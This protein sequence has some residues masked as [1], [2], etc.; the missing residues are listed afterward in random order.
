MTHGWSDSAVSETRP[1]PNGERAGAA[2]SSGRSLAMSL[3]GWDLLP[4]T[5]LLSRPQAGRGPAPQ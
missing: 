2:D 4:P 5:E 1:R 3:P